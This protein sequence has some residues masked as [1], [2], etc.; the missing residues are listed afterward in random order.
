M[1]SLDSSVS[2]K[3][4]RL[5]QKTALP[6]YTWRGSPLLAM[7]ATARKQAVYVLSTCQEQRKYHLAGEDYLPPRMATDSREDATEVDYFKRATR[8]LPPQSWV[9]VRRRTGVVGGDIYDKVITCW[10]ARKLP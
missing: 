1:G 10:G 3:F 8:I 2:G 9:E 7:V 6:V 4:A 5:S